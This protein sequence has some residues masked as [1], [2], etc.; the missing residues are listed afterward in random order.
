[1]SRLDVSGAA[2]QITAWRP[3]ADC[4]GSWRRGERVDKLP[5]LSSS[6][7]WGMRYWFFLSLVAALLVGCGGPNQADAVRIGERTFRIEGPPIAGGAIEPN[8]RLAQRLCPGGYRVLDD[9][10]HKGGLDRADWYE[11]GTTTIWVVKCI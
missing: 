7:G 2:W 10:E 11:H 3:A 8:Q 1:V 6:R 5:A 9:K 4:T